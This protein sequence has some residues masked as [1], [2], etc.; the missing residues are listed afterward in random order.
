ML[1]SIL[2]GLDGSVFSESAVQLG[3][4]WARKYSAQLIGLA[5]VDEVTI[6]APEPVPIGGG[7]FKLV[8]DEELLADAHRIAEQS[9]T[10]IVEQCAIAGVEVKARKLV[11]DASEQILCESQ[12]C[13]LILLGQQTC[14]HHGAH[15]GSCKT[16]ASVV[17]LS[18]RPVV[19]APERLREG[20][21]VLIGFDGS[22]HAARALQMFQFLQLAGECPIYV[23]SIDADHAAA[24]RRVERAVDFLRVHEIDAVPV[25][26]ESSASPAE[27]LLQQSEQLGA[28]LLVLGAYGKSALREFILGSITQ[29][30]LRESRVP[31]FLYH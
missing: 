18:P 12:R 6:R 10:K 14:F 9:L 8:K 1:R 2:V 13:D 22:A 19:V 17:K 5:V 30:L 15:Q 20:R 29:Q 26:I 25:P 28:S 3:L 11:G 24:N 27:V 21:G 16:L 7:Y 31:L 4:Q 23:V